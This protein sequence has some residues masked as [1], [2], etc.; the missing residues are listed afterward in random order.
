MVIG[1][2]YESIT[3]TDNESEIKILI[4]D[5]IQ[6]VSNYC[7]ICKKVFQIRYLRFKFRLS[8]IVIDVFDFKNF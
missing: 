1:N 2:E 8:I 3:E 4:K 7:N 5:G 6:K